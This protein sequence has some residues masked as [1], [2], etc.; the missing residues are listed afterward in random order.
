[1]ILNSSKSGRVRDM[2][3]ETDLL[4][5]AGHAAVAAFLRAR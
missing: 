2:K 1:M 5:Q 4:V 3:V